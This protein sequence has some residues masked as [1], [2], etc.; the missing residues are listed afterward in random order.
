MTDYAAPNRTGKQLPESNCLEAVAW[1]QL[2]ESNYL[3]AVAG[4]QLPRS[5]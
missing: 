2:P 3:E 5:N 1:K 4:K